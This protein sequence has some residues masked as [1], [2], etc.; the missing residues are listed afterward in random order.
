[1]STIIPYSSHLTLSVMFS[2]VR[3]ALYLLQANKYL[4]NT[5]LVKKF[6]HIENLQ[7]M[8]LGGLV[9]YHRLDVDAA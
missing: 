2:P 5:Y 3:Q 8:K 9:H 7:K 1:M 4:K 6:T